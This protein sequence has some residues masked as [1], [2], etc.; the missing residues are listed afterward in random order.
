[1]HRGGQPGRRHPK[2]A[3]PRPTPR[4]SSRIL[5]M[6]GEDGLREMRPGRAGTARKKIE[7]DAR[8]RHC[9]QDRN[10]DRRGGEEETAGM[11]GHGERMRIIIDAMSQLELRGVVQR[12]ARPPHRRRWHRN[13]A[14]RPAP[15][16]VSRPL[17]AAA[18]PRCCVAL[19]DSKKSP[20]G[21]ILIHSRVVSRPGHRIPGKAPGRRWCFR[22]TPGS[23]PDRRCQHRLRPGGS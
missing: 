4:Q 11:N 15:S 14:W 6:V 3:T 1:M 2:I 5:H 23:P 10:G 16:L 18:R 17:R 22:I 9:R 7:T 8:H 12:Y 13:S 20:T 19:R 21:E